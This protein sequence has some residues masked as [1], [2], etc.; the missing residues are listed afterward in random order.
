MPRGP[1]GLKQQREWIIRGTKKRS[2]QRPEWSDDM[3]VICV[4]PQVGF[5]FE[6]RWS[7]LNKGHKSVPKAVMPFKSTTDDNYIV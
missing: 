1:S 3:R 2:A 6:N 4:W 7:F 5:H